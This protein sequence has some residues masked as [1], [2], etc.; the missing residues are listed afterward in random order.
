[1]YHKIESEYKYLQVFPESLD[2][3][4]VQGVAMGKLKV[5]ARRI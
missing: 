4:D 2:T 1:M 3:L 5:P